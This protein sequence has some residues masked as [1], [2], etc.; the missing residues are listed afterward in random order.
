MTRRVL[1]V[2]PGLTIT[3]WGIVDGDGATG[4]LVDCGVIK[5]RPKAPRAYRLREIADGI[6]TIIRDY[7]PAELAVEQQFVA[8]NVRSA[9]VIG[10][11]RAAA[12]IAAADADI[13]VFEFAPTSVKQSVTGWGGAPKE[14]VQQMVAVQ[15]GLTELTGPLD[16]SDALAV[17]LTRL[18]DIRLELALARS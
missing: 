4:T 17:A 3:G 14:Q 18:G 11:A 2:D 6:R 15:L 8:L 5:T 16:I 1:G 7:G 12:M 9:M 13:P 10:E